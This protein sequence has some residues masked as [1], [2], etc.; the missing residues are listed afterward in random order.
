M[1]AGKITVEIPRYL[2]VELSKRLRRMKDGDRRLLVGG[3]GG[4]SVETS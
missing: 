1:G 2:Q 3:V 4:I